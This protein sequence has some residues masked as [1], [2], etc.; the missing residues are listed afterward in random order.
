[1]DASRIEFDAA[2]LQFTTI[3]LKDICEMVVD[4]FEPLILQ[5]Q[6]QTRIEIDACITVRA[7][8]TRL[9]QILRNLIANALRYS[10]HGT[11]ICI[12]AA[13]DEEAETVAISVIDRGY[14]VPTDKQEI[15]FDRFVRLERD[16]HGTVRGSGLGLSITRQ[17]V[18][19]MNGSIR[20]ESNGNLEEGSAFIFTLPLAKSN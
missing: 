16:M 3:P 15:I 4:L 19:A 8:E 17:L 18:Q 20:V 6:R 1:M 14:G 5:E 11:P 2:A 13:V 12:E 9:K 7:D 10:A